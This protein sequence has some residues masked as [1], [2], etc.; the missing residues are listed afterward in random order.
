M[1]QGLTDDLL[2]LQ[3]QALPQSHGDGGPLQADVL[4]VDDVGLGEGG[5]ALQHVFQLPDVPRPVVGEQLVHS[6][7]GE[8]LF[9]HVV[10]LENFLHQMVNEEAD[11]LL[12][13]PQGGQ[14]QGE[15][16]EAVVQVLAELPGGHLL[17]QAAVGGGQNA[18]VHGD[19]AGGAHP[20]DHLVLN[21][22]QQLCLNV[23]GDL[24][25]LV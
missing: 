23:Q 15:G 17:P 20:A 21:G 22:P 1:G 11:V 5:G 8:D 2:L 25:D 16:A 7:P 19:E 24:A 10:F 14:L 18:H 12:A 4:G 13:V 6:L 3:P 9:G